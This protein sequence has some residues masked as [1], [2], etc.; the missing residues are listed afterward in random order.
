M[1]SRCC[2]ERYG[3]P[4]AGM[5]S[6]DVRTM[7][8][9]KLAECSAAI[10]SEPILWERWRGDPNDQE[11]LLQLML[12]KN[13]DPNIMHQLFAASSHP[14]V[15]C[16]FMYA[17]TLV[18]QGNTA[19]AEEL[20]WAILDENPYHIEALITL[21]T[22]FARN[23]CQREAQS[24]ADYILM[25]N[26]RLTEGW[27]I[28][29][30]ALVHGGRWY[31]AV[32]ALTTAIKM[33]DDGLTI[34]LVS[35]TRE[36]ILS[37]FHA[38]RAMCFAKIGIHDSQKADL[39]VAARLQPEDSSVTKDLI[40]WH[41]AHATRKEAML[42]L[43]KGMEANHDKQRWVVMA[44]AF[45]AQ[46][47]SVEKL[48][49]VLEASTRFETPSAASAVLAAISLTGDSSI[50]GAILDALFQKNP[51]AGVMILSIITKT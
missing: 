34:G 36:E 17:V 11:C 44:G 45:Y 9:T 29:S 42:V 49:M 23:K 6:V 20:L 37:G 30:G 31:D 21:G 18:Q 3:P 13:Q 25:I 16:Q 48:A 41:E 2:L 4:V 14:S 24:A 1:K 22:L 43:E 26:P 47:R 51:E 10:E 38:S 46:W 15:Y 33:V 27:F 39:E 19:R 28:R 8:I 40:L 5:D 7:H 32:S 50:G 35:K 12:Y